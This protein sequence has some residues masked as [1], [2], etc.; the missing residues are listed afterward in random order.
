[1]RFGLKRIN[2]KRASR[3]RRPSISRFA[4]TL[5]ALGRG[6]LGRISTAVGI[7]WQSVTQPAGLQP[8]TDARQSRAQGFARVP[9][10]RVYRMVVQSMGHDGFGAAV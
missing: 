5:Q 2:N 3:E 6:D 8:P 10:N 7:P 9:A 1:M 4:V